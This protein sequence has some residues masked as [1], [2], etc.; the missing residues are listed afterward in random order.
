MSPFHPGRDHTPAE[1]I[2]ITSGEGSDGPGVWSPDGEAV[3][4][5]LYPQRLDRATKRPIGDAQAIDAVTR[6]C[7]REAGV[8][9][10]F[11]YYGGMRRWADW[12][13]YD[14]R[15]VGVETHL[16]P[17]WFRSIVSLPQHFA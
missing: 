9:Y 5:C 16:I 17:E 12:D 14:I 15:R 10:A 8:Q 6:D 2:A 3:V 13:D 1:W 7:L 4:R 11:S